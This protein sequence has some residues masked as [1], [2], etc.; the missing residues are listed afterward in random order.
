MFSF[1]ARCTALMLVALFVAS[2]V[3]LVSFESA[4]QQPSRGDGSGQPV[5]KPPHRGPAIGGTSLTLGY[6]WGPAKMPP[7]ANDF[8]PHFD[9]PGTYS[10]DGAPNQAPYPN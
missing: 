7:P 1:T 3:A 8:G 10:L 9:Y 4:A 5:V 2:S 6:I